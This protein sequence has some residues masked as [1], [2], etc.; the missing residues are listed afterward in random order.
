MFSF[1]CLDWSFHDET[2]E[3]FVCRI[4]LLVADLFAVGGI[5]AA[6]IAFCLRPENQK[7]AMKCAGSFNIVAGKLDFLLKTFL[8][9]QLNLKTLERMETSKNAIFFARV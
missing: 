6:F 5:L 3:F 2:L 9:L 7:T 4:V 8:V 1:F